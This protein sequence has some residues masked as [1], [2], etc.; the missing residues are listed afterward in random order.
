MK[1]PLRYQITECDCGIISLANAITYLYNREE[2]ETKLI[3]GIFEYFYRLN[4]T[5]D[6]GGISK[7][8]LM[9][10]TNVL[11]SEN[12]KMKMI[13]KMIDNDKYNSTINT[14]EIIDWI[15]SGGVAIPRVWQTCEH[16]ILVT[17]I[18]QN[19][20]Y[21]FDPYLFDKDYYTDDECVEDI[22][23]QP[24]KYNRKVK[25]ERFNS[26]TTKDFSLVEN[27]NSGILLIK[28]K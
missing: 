4:V 19:Y 22:Y 10:L 5:K 7:I 26:K 11:N 24:Y 27:E 12:T 25:I 16:Y 17:K 20:V 13:F 18:D 21:I 15:N 9:S 2:I 1:I 14:K 3:Y 6:G 23:D 28:R 8:N